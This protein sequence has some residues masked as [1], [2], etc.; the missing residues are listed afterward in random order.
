MNSCARWSLAWTGMSSAMLAL[1][2]C[3]AIACCIIASWPIFLIS[4]RCRLTGKDSHSLRFSDLS[5]WS[6]TLS[7]MFRRSMGKVSPPVV[8]SEL[9][10]PFSYLVCGEKAKSP[11][12]LVENIGGSVS[13]FCPFDSC[14]FFLVGMVEVAR[15]GDGR[16]VSWRRRG[17]LRDRSCYV[18]SRACLSQT[19]RRGQLLSACWLYRCVRG[20]QERWG[21]SELN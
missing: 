7:V 17:R 3:M 16:R 21:D 14:C 9:K 4:S 12:M 5:D 15:E 20:G 13:S 2:M 10:P 8:N 19:L 6:R 18:D 11:A 1:P